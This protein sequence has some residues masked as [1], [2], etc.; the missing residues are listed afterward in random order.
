MKECWTG[1]TPGGCVGV[2]GPSGYAKLD[3]MTTVAANLCS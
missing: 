1:A 2:P 3:A